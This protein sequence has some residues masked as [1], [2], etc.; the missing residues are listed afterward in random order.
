MLSVLERYVI[1]WWNEVW[2]DPV[3]GSQW[4]VK[5]LAGLSG[6]QIWMTDVCKHTALV[7]EEVWWY[8][9]WWRCWWSHSEICSRIQLAATTRDRLVL[10]SDDCWSSS[11]RDVE[12]RHVVNDFYGSSWVNRDF[13][14]ES[15]PSEERHFRT[16]SFRELTNLVYLWSPYVIRQAIIF[17]CCFFF[18]LYFPR[19]I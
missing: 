8:R 7:N 2:L 17:S 18:L 19:L 1:D 15:C 10:T 5:S 13:T 3:L 16:L 4:L 12:L 11:G 6:R 14:G 9:W